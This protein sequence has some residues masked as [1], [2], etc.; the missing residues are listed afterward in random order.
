[1]LL[2]LACSSGPASLDPAP[3]ASSPPAVEAAPSAVPPVAE[4]E[5]EPA[6]V[7]EAVVPVAPGGAPA[8]LLLWTPSADGCDVA[9]VAL[10]AL[11]TRLITHLVACPQ[12]ALI[13]A[14]GQSV[15]LVPAREDRPAML[16]AGPEGTARALP[17]PPAQKDVR[18]PESLSQRYVLDG[19]TVGFGLEWATVVDEAGDCGGPCYSGH[20]RKDFRLEGGAWL[21]GTA[22]VDHG[23]LVE[24]AM[25]TDVGDYRST[26]E[27]DGAVISDQTGVFPDSAWCVTPVSPRVA[28]AVWGTGEG[29]SS[30]APVVIESAGKW[31]TVPGL[32]AQEAV[33]MDR[34][35]HYLIVRSDASTMVLDLRGP[36]VV[37]RG[38][39]TLMAWPGS[40]P[41]PTWTT[42]PVPPVIDAPTIGVGT[43]PAGDLTTGTLPPSAPSPQPA[44]PPATSAPDP[45]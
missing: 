12:A 6:M 11:T 18:H 29:E 3:S 32:Q 38:K 42:S 10:P 41:I 34:V 21:E 36:A 40:S 28:S 15:L 2:L 30:G 4:P 24:A 31:L 35:A 33:Y 9:L 37:W 14:S 19:E 26:A 20:V 43:P 1:M 7:P 23:S 45:R 13:S 27:G 44:Q 22:L 25:D 5:E 16:V 8:T 17:A 39:G